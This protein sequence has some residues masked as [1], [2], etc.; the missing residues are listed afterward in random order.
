MGSTAARW[1]GEGRRSGAE[2][3]VP[4]DLPCPEGWKPPFPYILMLLLDHAPFWVLVPSAEVVQMTPTRPSRCIPMTCP[5]DLG[6]GPWRARPAGRM[7]GSTWMY[8]SPFVTGRPQTE[9]PPRTAFQ[10]V[11]PSDATLTGVHL[12]RRQ[13]SPLTELHWHL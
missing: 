11:P 12:C 1:G 4:G 8:L 6:A 2:G 7:A 13:A 10:P 3:L 9:H 5:P